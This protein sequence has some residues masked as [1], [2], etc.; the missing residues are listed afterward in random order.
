M[1]RR[2]RTV[3]LAAVVVVAGV[4]GAQADTIVIGTFGIIS[5]IEPQCVEDSDPCEP[6]SPPTAPFTFLPPFL[7]LT[8]DTDGF[9]SDLFV[10]FNSI[11]VLFCTSVAALGDGSVYPSDAGACG[12]PLGSAAMTLD[13]ISPGEVAQLTS[14]LPTAGFALVR[15]IVTDD[16][17][18]PVERIVRQGKALNLGLVCDQQT[19][20]CQDS[21]FLYLDSV[22]V[23]EPTTLLLFAG[24]LGTAFIRTLRRRSGRG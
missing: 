15:L 8:N 9:Y 11:E 12:G 13:P 21:T 10:N 6:V 19:G 18:N 17:G 20:S 3:V 14:T 4:S 2:F 24:G 1:L 16:S 7:D 23:P 5:E 22:P